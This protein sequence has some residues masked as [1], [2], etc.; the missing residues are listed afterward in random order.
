[1]DTSLQ[2]LIDRASQ[3]AAQANDLETKEEE[4]RRAR[5]SADQSAKDAWNEVYKQLMELHN[6]LHD[7]DG[8]R[9]SKLGF[10]L[11]EEYEKYQRQL[12]R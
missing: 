5:Q 7:Q 12:K 2:E 10:M 3:I 9:G 4:A 8:Y 6:R 1:M 11:K